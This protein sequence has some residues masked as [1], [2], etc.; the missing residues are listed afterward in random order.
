MLFYSLFQKEFFDMIHFKWVQK[1]GTIYRAWGGFHALVII[2]SPELMEVFSFKYIE[3]GQYK[4]S[5][6]IYPFSANFE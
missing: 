4:T 6:C 3:T 5:A 1:Y 2:S